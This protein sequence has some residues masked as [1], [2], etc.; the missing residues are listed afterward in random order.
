MYRNVLDTCLL[1]LYCATL[2]NSIQPSRLLYGSLRIFCTHGH[3]ACEWRWFYFFLFLSVCLLLLSLALLP[4]LQ[5][6]LWC[7][8]DIA[9]ANS[10]I[11]SLTLRKNIRIF[12]AHVILTETFSWITFVRSRKLFS[13]PRCLIFFLIGKG[14]WALSNAFCATMKM[15]CDFCP[16]LIWCFTWLIVIY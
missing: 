6:S 10:S 8:L 15:L 3:A 14:C 11:L 1:I 5:P 2:L 12:T 7:G 16:L 9:K 4:W 13:I